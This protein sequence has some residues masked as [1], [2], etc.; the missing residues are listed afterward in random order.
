[1]G[2]VE[3]T[4]YNAFGQVADTIHYT[5]RISTTGLTGG[6]VTATLTSRIGQIADT[7]RD[8][9]RQTNYTVRGAVR[10]AITWETSTQSNITRYTYNA[11]GELATADQPVDTSARTLTA[12][13]YDRRGSLARVTQDSAAGGF[14]RATSSE[15]DAFGR[16]A[17]AY[18]ANGNPPTVYSY[19]RLGRQ[20]RVTDALGFAQ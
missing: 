16:V 4:V 9:R 8:A 12:Y 5:G 19:D 2:E 6:L 13:Q 1:L 18:D 20:I 3:E 10:E 15:Y 7:T 17:R 11:F 14:K